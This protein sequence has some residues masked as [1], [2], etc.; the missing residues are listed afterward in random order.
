MTLL[1]WF[2]GAN[3]VNAAPTIAMSPTTIGGEF[4]PI[5]FGSQRV[6]CSRLSR[7]LTMPLLPKPPTGRPVDASSAISW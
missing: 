3:G 2:A 4:V 5:W 1:A 6:P 7:R